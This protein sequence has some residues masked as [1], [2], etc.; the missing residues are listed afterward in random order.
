LFQKHNLDPG[1]VYDAVIRPVRDS[2]VKDLIDFLNGTGN[3]DHYEN[4]FQI[5]EE[6]L[7]RVYSQGLHD[8]TFPEV[9]E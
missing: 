8:A 3:H 5:V 6:G 4:V 2:V 9:N 1:E 7:N